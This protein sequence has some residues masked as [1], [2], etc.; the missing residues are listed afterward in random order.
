MRHDMMLPNTLADDPR[1][2]LRV[3]VIEHK[4][5][6]A[7]NVAAKEE[8]EATLGLKLDHPNI[9]RT[10][11]YANRELAPTVKVRRTLSNADFDCSPRA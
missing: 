9:V 11:K 10:F 4:S 1:N 8:V 3:Q 2:S 7:E 5:T 6:P